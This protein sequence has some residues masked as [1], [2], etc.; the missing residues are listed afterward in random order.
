M[1]SPQLLWA[2]CL[3]E[4][5]LLEQG[6]YA[7]HWEEQSRAE[8]K[9]GLLLPCP[10]WRRLGLFAPSTAEVAVCVYI[11]HRSGSE[12]Q[13]DQESKAMLSHIRSPRLVWINETLS[14]EGEHNEEDGEPSKCSATRRHSQPRKEGINWALTFISFLHPAPIVQCEQRESINN[15]TLLLPLTANS[16]TLYWWISTVF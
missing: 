1:L 6:L 14:S 5:C 11:H 8:D 3:C 9:A 7:R 15:P 10:G 2:I 13:E 16:S 12:A 4:C